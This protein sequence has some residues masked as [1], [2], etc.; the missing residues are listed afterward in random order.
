VSTLNIGTTAIVAAASVFASSALPVAP[1]PGVLIAGSGVPL[2]QAAAGSG[3]VVVNEFAPGAY[4][5]LRNNSLSTVDIGGF[6]LGLCGPDGV[7]AEVRVSLGRALAPGDFYVIASSSFTGAPA[8]QTHWDVLPGG[9][10]VLLD[11][12]HAWGDGTAVVA[13]SPCGEGVPAPT[14]PQ[15]S[16][17][18]N[19][20]S[21]DTGSNIA[22]FACRIRSPG[23]PNPAG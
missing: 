16:T 15:A 6:N 18:R 8:D 11:P 13:D 3:A 7:T 23:E 12:D 22:D 1:P 9:G 5:E 10:A 14:C 21:T 20:V 19:A 17:A 2:G 4:V